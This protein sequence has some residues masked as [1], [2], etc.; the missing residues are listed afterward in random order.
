MTPLLDAIDSLLPTGGRK[1]RRLLTE[2]EAASARVV[3]IRIRT[4][5]DRADRWEYALEVLG[6]APFRAGCRQSLSTEA[7]TRVRLGGLVPVRHRDGRVIIDE[8]AL[9]DG[10]GSD[11]AR[12]GNVGWKALSKQPTEGVEDQ[13]LDQQR[14]RARKGMAVTARVD[15]V[16][17][18]TAA[19]GMA[20]RWN[21]AMT[22]IDADVHHAIQL[23]RAFVPEYVR[24]LLVAGAELPIAMDP[25]RPDRAI[26]DWETAAVAHAAD[27]QR[28]Q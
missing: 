2:G 20:E 1:S 18:T 8:P 21:I 17:S 6:E 13:R 27:E 15:S 23:E 5:G 24:E 11:A 9:S 14:R 7:R 10:E 19:M 26:V 12:T 25:S 3:G 4:S 28:T 22:A 16:E